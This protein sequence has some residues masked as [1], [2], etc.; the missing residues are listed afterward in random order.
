VHEGDAGR[1]V[2]YGGTRGIGGLPQR[3]AWHRWTSDGDG[4]LDAAKFV[5]LVP[6]VEVE[7]RHE[8]QEAF[9]LY[10]MTG[11][12]NRDQDPR[13]VFKDFLFFYN[14]YTIFHFHELS[15]ASIFL[16]QNFLNLK[17]T[18]FNEPIN[19][20]NWFSV[21]QQNQSRPDLLVF[22]KA[23]RFSSWIGHRW[24]GRPAPDL[25]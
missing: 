8:L 11:L 5:Q 14:F 21:N 19:L 4:L 17:K 6:R 20:V 23:D 10:K 7:L 2:S 25:Q 16:F 24:V 3:H 22:I 9:R 18:V 12:R 1:G 15:N 13:A